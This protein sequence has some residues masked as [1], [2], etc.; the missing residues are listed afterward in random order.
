[1]FA[2]FYM[3]MKIARR[4]NN[5]KKTWTL[6]FHKRNYITFSQFATDLKALNPVGYQVLNIYCT[7]LCGTKT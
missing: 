4:N 3:T 7:D 6:K 5:N 1:M 2:F